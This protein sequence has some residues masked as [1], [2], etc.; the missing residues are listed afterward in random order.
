MTVIFE[1]KEYEVLSSND[2]VALIK[3]GSDLRCVSTKDLQQVKEETAKP[4][5]K[6]SKSK[7]A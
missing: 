2:E 6:K 7:R 5:E 3:S 4:A 1:G